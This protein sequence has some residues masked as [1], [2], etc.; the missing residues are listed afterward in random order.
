MRERQFTPRNVRGTTTNDNA[1]AGYV[2]EFVTS[3]L[4]S[5]SAISL[6][7]NVVANVTSITLTPGDW[8]V[9]GAVNY[10]HSAATTSNY[11]G[12]TSTTSATLGSQGTY[13]TLPF[14]VSASSAAVRQA[15]PTVRI[16]VSVNTIVYLVALATISG[17]TV[18]AH[19]T[20]NARRVR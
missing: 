7:T 3:T 2:G 9:F 19:G 16:S 20:I 6:T 14:G 18:S 13:F 12:G 11:S 1:A 4:A 10:A 15:V 8:D 17:G 5:G